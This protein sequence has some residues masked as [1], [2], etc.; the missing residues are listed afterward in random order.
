MLL[1][2][3]CFC[4]ALL[5]NSRSALCVPSVPEL[6]PPPVAREFRGAWVAT[7]SN[8]D[9][10]TEPGLSTD[11]QKQELIAILDRAQELGLNAIV[12][13][14]RPACDA[15]YQS[16]L[17]P[18]SAYLTGTMGQA[19]DP[20]YDPLE[21]AVAEAHARGIELHVW[22]NPYR[23]RH[24]A[25]KGKISDDHVSK[26]Y[27]EWV[28]EYGNYLWLDPGV[29][30]ALDHTIAVILDVVNRYDIDGVHMDDYFYPYPISEDGKEVPFP[31]DE[32]YVRAAAADLNTPQDRGDWRRENVNRLVERLHR[33]IHEAKPWVKFGIS[34]FGIWRPGHPETIQG[35][36][37]YGK[38]YADARKWLNEGWVDYFTPQL[39]WPIDQ[40]PQSYPVLLEWWRGENKQNRHL[41][42]GNYTSRVAGADGKKWTAD[43]IVNQIEITRKQVKEPG[44]IHFSMKALMRDADGLSTLLRDGVY[45]EPAL[46]PAVPWL[47]G[48]EPSPEIPEATLRSRG[49]KSSLEYEG[50]SNPNL[51]VLQQFDGDNWST[52]IAPGAQ[53]EFAL[54]PASKSA[55]LS[56]VDRYGRQSE[57]LLVEIERL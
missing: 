56:A 53:R 24:S 37:Q 20:V 5:A 41:W 15:L 46:V 4:L 45:A 44:N 49:G 39:Y 52:Q 16:S 48:D 1:T 27:P 50:I 40:K 17:E 32:S 30:E 25:A 14:I 19:P 23:A 51:W 3:I 57:P 9:W 11:E 54:L 6:E 13:Q 47:A 36:D 7:V 35:F 28:R 26:K 34:P 33:E 31:D 8:I 12:L 38:L 2:R 10:P 21:F 29:P 43:E 42:P 55:A 18:W 22:L